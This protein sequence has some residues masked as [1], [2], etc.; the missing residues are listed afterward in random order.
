V[1]HYFLIAARF[2]FALTI[3]LIP[4]RWRADLWGRPFFPLYSDYTDFHLFSSDLALIYMLVFWGCSLLVDPRRVRAGNGLVLICL[5]GLTVAGW[6]SVFASQDPMLSRYHAVRFIFLL[7]FY[8]FIVNE[9]HSPV[10]VIAPVALQII[11]QS[12]TAIGQSLAQSS[13]GLQTLGEHLLDPARSGVSVV[14][15]NGFRFL[16]AYG[17]SDH[18]NIL[19]GC[20]TFGLVLLLAVVVYGKGRQPLLA[21]SV[22]LVVFPALVMTF[23]RS[24]WLSLMVAGSFMV[25]FEAFARRWNSVKRAALLGMLSLLVVSP[26]VTM[27]ISL[28]QSR[29]NSGNIASDDPMTER[30]FLMD[31]GNTLFVE[32]AAFGVGLGASPLA[33][34]QRY[35]HFPLDFQPPH[36]AILNSAM[37]TGVLGGVFYLLLLFMPWIMFAARWRDLMNK[38]MV[39]G[40]LALLLAVSIVGLFD[41]YTWMYAPGRLW[42]WLGWGLFSAAWMEAA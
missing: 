22:F 40:A 6:V 42:Q 2:A 38:P 13:L 34:K 18:P 35:K 37:E 15:G 9:I 33:M 19:G 23:S 21:S 24:A 4:L 10:W 12:M 32:H 16:R 11:I 31:A 29:V 14:I 17:L 39:M 26:F 25:G 41:Y 30:A 3:L 1:S 20:I 7:L 5:T 27:N 28:F 36:Y 8:L